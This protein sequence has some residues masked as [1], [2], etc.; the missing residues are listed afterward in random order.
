MTTLKDALKVASTHWEG[1]PGSSVMA[2]MATK[3]VGALGAEMDLGELGPQ[4]GVSLLSDLRGHFGLSPKSVQSYYQ[5]FTRLLALNGVSTTLWPKAPTPPRVKS[6]EPMKVSDLGDLIAWFRGKGWDN[7]ADL[8]VLMGATGMRV[9]RE[10]LGGEASMTW[11]PPP[12]VDP[13]DPEAQRWGTL[14]ILGKG[15]HER[16]IPVVEP[17]AWNLL[18]DAGRMDAMQATPYGT[19][20]ERWNKGVKAL[21]IKTKLATPHSVRHQ[22]ACTVLA[23]SGGNLVMVQEL[24]GHADLATTARYLHVDLS[25]KAHA[26][27][28]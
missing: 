26:L 24:L 1:R 18:G 21:G 9:E 28:L 16:K 4:H 7:S 13:E 8:A 14:T 27:G 6:R 12:P 20:L 23:K 15:G 19:H 5:A 11:E 22:Y 25:A 3:C 17:A 10:A 2:S